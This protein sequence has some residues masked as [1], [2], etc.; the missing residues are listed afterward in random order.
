MRRSRS[1]KKYSTLSYCYIAI[2]IRISRLT[3]A[4]AV[5]LFSLVK[6]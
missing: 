2:L 4:Q 3:M 5:C 6:G 1:V